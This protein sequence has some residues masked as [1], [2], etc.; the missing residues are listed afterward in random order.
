MKLAITLLATSLPCI[1]LHVGTMAL[2]GWLLGAT[3]EEVSW[4]YGPPY[5][6][7]RIGRV[8]CR[9]GVFPFGGYARFKGD[10]DVP[11]SREEIMFAAD[12]EPPGFNDLHPMRRVAI[13]ASGCL[14][15]ILLAASC[16]GAWPAV[17][18]LARGFVQCIPFAPWTPAWVPGGRELAGRFVSLFQTGPYRIALGVLAAKLAAINLLPVPPLNGGHI[19]M[20][21]VEWK[22]RLPEQVTEPVTYVGVLLSLCVVLYWA[23]RFAA[24]LIWAA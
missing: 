23:T 11:K 6:R 7:F 13:L 24:V 17:R 10:Q 21:L 16:L 9:F 12:I 3:V 2:A 4:F 8:N 20:T 18:S 19:V 15:L 14:T 1:F 5:I 22:K